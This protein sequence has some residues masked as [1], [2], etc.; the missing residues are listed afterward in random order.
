MQG[1]FEKKVKEKLDELRLQPTVPVWENIESRIQP[2]KRRRRLVFWLFFLLVLLTAAGWWLVVPSNSSKPSIVGQAK[3]IEEKKTA[4]ESQKS[5]VTEEVTTK[6]NGSTSQKKSIDEKTI[7]KK[8][9]LF[10]ADVSSRINDAERHSLVKI[11]SKERK[12]EFSTNPSQTSVRK[13]VIARKENRNKTEANT[14]KQDQISTTSQTTTGV[15]SV[16]QSKTVEPNNTAPP[17]AVDSAKKKIAASK[18]KWS[19]KILFS[20]GWSGVVYA[21]SSDKYYSSPSGVTNGGYGNMLDREPS[22]VTKGASFSVGYAKEKVFSSRLSLSGGLQY[23]YYSTHQ[24]VGVY[25]PLDTAV[26]FQN[27]A[28]SIPGYFSSSSSSAS[29]SLTNYTS[30]YHTIELPVGLQ[31]R[32]SKRVPLLLSTT[33]SYGRLLSSNALTFDD[34]SGVYYANKQNNRKSFVNTAVGLQYTVLNKTG[35]KLSAGPAVQ[36]DLLSLQ[37]IGASQHLLFAGLKTAVEF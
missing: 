16:A 2:E 31:W 18:K 1:S 15:D 10:L 34:A 6:A 14:L 35:W 5:S 8:K 36:Y 25:K 28:L 3:T 29:V 27:D 23:V 30:H 32:L 7:D 17:I 9:N 20:V 22:E 13:N 37:K 19:N 26:R 24:K 12:T 4:N 33:V 11:L 21:G